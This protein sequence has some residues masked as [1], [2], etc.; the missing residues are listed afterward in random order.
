MVANAIIQGLAVIARFFV[1]LLFRHRTVLENWIDNSR[2]GIGSR[3]S[4]LGRQQ[5]E[6]YPLDMVPRL[7]SLRYAYWYVHGWLSRWKGAVSQSDEA[8][9]VERL[10]RECTERT[11]IEFGFHPLEFN[12][13]RLAAD[14]SWRGLVIDGDPAMIAKSRGR[15]IFK[16]TR[17]EQHFLTLDNL[18]IVRKAFPKIGVLSI[19]VDGNDYWLLK[20]LIDLSPSVICVEYNS[21]FGLES[22]TV[23][24]DPNF[25]RH[26][27][28]EAGWYH[29]ASLTALSKICASHGYGLAA[30][31]EGGANAFFTQSGSLKPEEAW[32]PSVL[33]QRFS[34]VD[35]IGQW[36]AIKH[37]DYVRV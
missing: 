29:G 9:V 32:R 34:G 30:V 22:V 20:A 6:C 21:S 33:R 2:K 17:I 10:A 3:R 37:L 18:E 26:A 7:N 4:P 35:Q 36:Q 24:Y 28:H 12:C 27:K 16:N 8:A 31:S 14:P 23:P 1:A 5:L 25:D 19:D 15:T 13:I 11:F